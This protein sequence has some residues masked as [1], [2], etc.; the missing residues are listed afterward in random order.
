MGFDAGAATGRLELDTSDFTGGIM[1]AEG[2]ARI[3]PEVVTDFIANPLLGAVEIFKEL[4]ETAID[5]F[6]EVTS[7]AENMGLLS[8]K[9]GVAPEIFSQ[10]AQLAKTVHV[11]PEQLGMGIKM[12]EE[13]AA[14]ALESEGKFDEQRQARRQ[15]AAE[16]E[17]EYE[18]KHHGRHGKFDQREQEWEAE[19]QATNAQAAAFAKLGISLEDLHDNLNDPMALFQKI[20]D[21]IDAVP[22]PIERMRLA[23]ELL[24]ARQ[25]ALVPLLTMSKEHVEEFGKATQEMG[26]ITST[27][28]AKAA[29]TFTDLQTEAGIALEGIRKSAMMPILDYITAH[30]DQIQKEITHLSTVAQED[31]GKIWDYLKGPQGKAILDEIKADVN[32][33]TADIPAMG[34]ELKAI[35]DNYLTPMGHL[36]EYIAGKMENMREWATGT[37]AQG[38]PDE[39][40]V[41][42]LSAGLGHP[43]LQEPLP[44]H[45]RPKPDDYHPNPLG[46]NHDEEMH[47]LGKINKNIATPADRQRFHELMQQDDKS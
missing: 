15:K 16:Q 9:L 24:G 39:T 41:N 33:I 29:Q 8:A 5:T 37:D 23:T 6:T 10:W 22:D 18:Q 1:E 47:I 12:L 28:E 4:G 27:S 13:E 25:S 11:A 32:I 19:H 40:G 14:K 20:K 35:Y 3:F 31:I 21:A 2:I 30:K 42:M 46:D 34:R 17:L 7:D 45:M 26:G 38:R 43:L 36:I 44:P